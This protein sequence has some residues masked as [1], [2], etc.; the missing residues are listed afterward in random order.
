MAL[1]T[2]SNLVRRPKAFTLVESLIAVVIVALALTSALNMLASFARVRKVQAAQ[3]RAP[4]LAAELMSE[5]LSAEYSDPAAPDNWGVES[6]EVNGTRVLFDDVDDYDGW[7]AS[8]PQEKN[9]AVVADAA[10]WAETVAVRRALVASPGTDSSVE[11]GLRRITV[12]VEDDRGAVV[13]LVALRSQR[14]DSGDCP[15]AGSEPPIGG[16]SIKIQVGK[17]ASP[18]ETGITLLNEPLGASTPVSVPNNHPPN[19]VASGAPLSGP[20]PLTVSFNGLA[21]S[22]PD[23]GDTL[24]YLWDFGEQAPGLLPQMSHTYAQAGTYKV[25]LKVSDQYGASATATL[26]VTV[27]E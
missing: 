3:S 25:V 10:G 2:R 26:T 13:T 8:P 20:K 16:A 19:A 21:S 9:G 24:S 17:T 27:S 23:A 15:S 7:S 5:I 1:M 14:A 11:T 12:T 6:D 18:I 4:A 22:D